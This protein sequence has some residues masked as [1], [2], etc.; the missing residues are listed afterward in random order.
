M[1]TPYMRQRLIAI[2]IPPI[3]VAILATF[4][5]SCNLLLNVRRLILLDCSLFL[6]VRLDCSLFLLIRQ[7]IFLGCPSVD[8]AEGL[9]A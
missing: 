7:I 9:C 5:Q 1:V 2:I 8:D 3:A 4:W 6:L